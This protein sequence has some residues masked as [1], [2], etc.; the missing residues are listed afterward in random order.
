MAPGRGQYDIITVNNH[1][2][3]DWDSFPPFREI[4]RQAAAERLIESMDHPLLRKL[5][6]D[7]D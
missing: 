7:T 5:A 3:V 6:G 1:K 4:L 2:T